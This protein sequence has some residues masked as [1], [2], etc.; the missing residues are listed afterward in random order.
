VL[1]RAEL[2][3][4][5]L[6]LVCSY[7]AALVFAAASCA[8]I[9]QTGASALSSPLLVPLNVILQWLATQPDFIR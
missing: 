9:R 5:A 6:A 8:D 7:A 3:R 2:R 4:H 1:Q